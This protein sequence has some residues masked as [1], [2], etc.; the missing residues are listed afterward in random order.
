[1]AFANRGGGPSE[2]DPVRLR[3]AINQIRHD[4][5]SS[6]GKVLA[7]ATDTLL[8]YLD[9]KVDNAS[10]EVNATTHELRVKALGILTAMINDLAVTAGKL[11][12][13]SV[14]TAK[15]L[16]SNVTTAK[17]ADL[18]VTTGKLADSAVTAQKIASDAVT[19]VKILDSNVTGPKLAAAV[20]GLGLSQN[21]SGNLDVNVDGSTLEINADALRVKAGGIGSSH[22]TDGAALAEILDDDGAGSGLDADLLDGEHASAIHAVANLTTSEVDTSKVLKPNGSGGVG[23]QASSGGTIETLTTTETTA[24]KFLRPDTAGGVRWNAF[25]H[26]HTDW[27]GTLALMGLTG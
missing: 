4:A 1:M 2:S 8:E 9:G 24:D 10:I 13:D 21:G 25:S 3:R 23:W 20:A 27:F 7:D 14:I 12:V 11:A 5:S 22:L 26:K 18:N 15:I 17:I 6:A 19:T 16:D